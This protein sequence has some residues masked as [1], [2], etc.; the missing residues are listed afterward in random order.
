MTSGKVQKAAKDLWVS[1]GGFNV[2]VRQFSKVNVEHSIPY[3]PEV[4]TNL[5]LSIFGNDNKQNNFSYGLFGMTT[6][7]DCVDI[8]E[9]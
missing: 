4:W 8:K 7:G 2:V 1:S 9:T 5:S 6:T 3:N